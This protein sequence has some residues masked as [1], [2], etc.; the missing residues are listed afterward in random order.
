MATT[1]DRPDPLVER[2]RRLDSCAVSNA[3]D[4]LGI[5][6]RVS[7]SLRP[8][9]GPARVGGRVITVELGPAGD[10][11]STVHLCA[12][13]TDATD[14]DSVIVIAHQG[15]TDAAGWGGN[16]SRAARRR[17]AAGTL[18]DGAARDID[19]AIDIGYPVF[20][21]ST[22]PRT[23]RGRV[24][25]RCWGQGIVFDGVAVEQGDF[26]LADSTGVVFLPAERAG[27]VLDVAEAIA[28]KEA[29]MA[30]AIDAGAPV[31]EVMGAGYER[32]LER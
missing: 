19:E 27:E 7:V 11:A 1:P 12:G 16:L 2:L 4:S 30:E 24:Q 21:T 25:E 31:S 32:M 28:A 3:C 13:A 17:G 29:A 18:V 22:T 14:A 26:V 20:A 6:G 23:A 9:T 8:L 15:R 10:E 5:E